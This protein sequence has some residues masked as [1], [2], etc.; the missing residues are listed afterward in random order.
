MTDRE[1]LQGGSDDRWEIRAVPDGPPTVVVE[2]PTANLFVTPQAVVPLRVSAKDD[3]AL[4]SITLVFSR[5]R[6]AG[7]K[8]EQKQEEKS[9]TLF[10]GPEK[11]PAPPAAATASAGSATGEGDRRVVDYRW[12]LRPLELSPGMQLNFW[13]AAADY[14]PQ[15]GKS[16]PRQLIVITPQELQ[17]RITGRQHLIL[18]ELQRVLKMQRG[19]RAQVEALTI[20]LGEVGRVE[21]NDIDQFETLQLGQREVNQLLTSRGE[22]LPMHILALL[23]ELENNRIDS[24]DAQRCMEGLLAEIERLD[25]ELLTPIGRE[26]TIAI[27]TAQIAHDETNGAAPKADQVTAP[28]A[29]AGK[30]QE[31]VIAAL[32]TMVGQ[33]A[34]WDNYR[35]FH[36]EMTQLLRDQE[37]VA[38]RTSE[39]G[40]R[41]LARELRDLSPRDSAELKIAAGRQVEL[42]RLLDRTLQDMDQAGAELQTNDPAAAETVADAL[43]EARRLAISGQMRAAAAQVGQNQIGQAVAGQKQIAQDLQEVLDILANRRQHELARLVKK[44]RD[45]ETDLSAIEQRQAG[46]RQQLHEGNQLPSETARRDALQ[47]G[48]RRAEGD[49]AG[50]GVAGAAAGAIAGRGCR[51]CDAAGRGSDGRGRPESRSKRRRCRGTTR[52]GGRNT[53]CRGPPPIGRA[54]SPGRRRTG[55]G[56]ACAAGRHREAPASSTAKCAGRDQAAARAGTIAGR[57]DPRPGHCVA[58]PGP[59]ATVVANRRRRAGAA[60]CRGGGVPDGDDRRRGRYGSRRRAVGSPRAR[61]RNPAGSAGCPAAAGAVAGSPQAR[62]ARGQWQRRRRRRTRRSAGRGPQTPP[63]SRCRN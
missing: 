23:A 63:F 55:D 45:A 11:P 9:L 19:S 32:E 57:V 22:G 20:R 24:A 37:E 29:A 25:R 5:V 12:E 1:G 17:D 26:L 43:D 21:Q 56:A 38:K 47:Q 53:A 54:A 3:L 49:P 44:L 52:R 60:T 28:L 16:E 48:R 31:Q 41:T 13:A 14:Q 8:L 4:R 18:A 2:Q 35:R 6:P 50:N 33:L 40:R 27:K 42:A 10:T 51:P 46:V 36:R 34:R 30:H 58:R 15:N 7:E 59:P 61:R 62:G 39:V